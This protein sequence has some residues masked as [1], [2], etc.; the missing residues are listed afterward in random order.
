ME[1]VI[2]RHGLTKERKSGQEDIGRPL[3]KVSK[4]FIPRLGKF[5]EV[6]SSP[7]R[8]CIDTARLASNITPCVIDSLSTHL[9]DDKVKGHEAWELI[10]RCYYTENGDMAE[11]PLSIVWKNM[12]EIEQVAWKKIT[13]TALKH[14]FC[15]DSSKLWKRVL[16]CTHQFHA[17][18]LA[19]HIA[20]TKSPLTQ[21]VRE[22][23]L[24]PGGAITLHTK[25]MKLNPSQNRPGRFEVLFV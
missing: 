21:F 10:E 11:L 13:A 23:Y 6:F 20:G 17:Q 24:P 3:M 1:I 16:I 19:M 2:I 15:C 22:I 8:R 14:I 7:A 25:I 4:E 9:W 5:D 12:T 18:V